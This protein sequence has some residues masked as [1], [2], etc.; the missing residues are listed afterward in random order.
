MQKAEFQIIFELLHHKEALSIPYRQLA[1]RTGTSIGSVHNT[2]QHLDEGGFLVAS[3]SS[4][5]MRRRSAL[6]DRWAQAYA[7][8]LKKR[9]LLCRFA[10]L[11][12]QVQQQWR[13]ITLPDG[14]D[15][16]G[17]PAAALADNYLEP[18]RWDI[19]APSNANALIATRRMI[20]H[21]DGKIYV[22]QKFWQQPETPLLVVYAD[23]WATNDDRCLE[24]ANR[25]KTMLPI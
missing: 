16:G 13:S 6:L 11:S 9:R 1:E 8:G 17:E 10:F 23:L 4:K 25:I 19:Y 2:L 22:Y 24:A 7:D 5:I 20:P 14:F 12:A 15:W 21:P 3:G 18:Q